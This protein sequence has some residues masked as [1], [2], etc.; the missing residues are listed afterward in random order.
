MAAKLEDIHAFL[1]L[2]E[3]LATAGQPLEEEFALIKD[4]GYE[5]VVNLVP[6][7]APNALAAEDKF[8]SVLG[9]E[10][11]AIPVIWTQPE[12]AD[13]E[14][15]FGVMDASQDKKVFVHCAANMRV[16]AFA[17]L[18]RTLHQK[19]SHEE[20]ERD[21]HQIWVPNERWNSFIQDA[22]QHYE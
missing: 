14:R 10:Y 15:F 6:P 3:R 8:V 5:V 4:A 7:T 22:T 1:R 21:L 18:Y 16:S 2:S 9:L 13:L 12:I 11:I 20:A 17:Y 19:V